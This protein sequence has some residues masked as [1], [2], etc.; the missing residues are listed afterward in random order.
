MRAISA[1]VVCYLLFVVVVIALLLY[2]MSQ[3]HRE[4][5]PDSSEVSVRP[6]MPQAY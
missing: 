6:N 5:L 3:Y 4:L 2:A 1:A